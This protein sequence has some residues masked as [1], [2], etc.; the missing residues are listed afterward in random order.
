MTPL[1]RPALIAWCS[2]VVALTTRSI[3]GLRRRPEVVLFSVL[4]PILF[5]LLF[6]Q[7]FAG[8]IQVQ[9]SDYASYLMAGI[10]GQSMVFASM[11]CGIAVAEDLKK[12]IIDRFRS[13]PMHPSSIL[14]ANTVSNLIVSAFSILTMIV[15]GMFVGWRFHLGIWN[16]LAGVGLL[17]LFAF[18]LS[19]VMVLLG[20]LLGDARAVNT[21][22]VFIVMPLSFLS[23]AFVPLETLSGWIKVFAAWN[24]VSVLVQACRSLFGN[25][26]SAP[27]PDVWPLQHPV[28]ATLGYTVLLIAVFVPLSVWAFRTRNNR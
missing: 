1:K 17:L 2:D 21:A 7:V 12:G 23:N 22:G 6:T 28:V 24:P 9:D 8:A 5:V 3:I 15:T 16:M 20:I 13:L 11:V 10:F 19:W 14:T 26:G 25:L 4:Q 18:A 27:V